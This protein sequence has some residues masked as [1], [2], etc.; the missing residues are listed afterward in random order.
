M[1]FGGRTP[2]E[3]F[4]E[5]IYQEENHRKIPNAEIFLP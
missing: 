1:I 5:I 3:I 2:V 4:R